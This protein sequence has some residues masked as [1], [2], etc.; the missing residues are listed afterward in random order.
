MNKKK[1]LKNNDDL[2]IKSADDVEEILAEQ[3]T[4]LTSGKATKEDVRKA[5]SIADK[6]GKKLDQAE[7]IY[8]DKNYDGK[9]ID[10]LKPRK[11]RPKKAVDQKPSKPKASKPKT[12]KP[13][14]KK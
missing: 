8:K 5:N 1:T 6:I 10:I 7:K 2:Q 12:V 9:P 13:K 11:K 14:G 4:I 3:L